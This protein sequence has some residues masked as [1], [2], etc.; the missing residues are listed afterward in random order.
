MDVIKKKFYRVK[1]VTNML[2]VKPGTI[3]K[4]ANEGKIPPIKISD[5]VLID[6]NWVDNLSSEKE[7][8][9]T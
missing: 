4:W 9:L 1:D 7:T 8:N 6:A 5:V 2:S 3:Y